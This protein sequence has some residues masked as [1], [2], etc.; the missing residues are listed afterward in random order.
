MSATFKKAAGAMAAKVVVT[1]MVVV[2]TPEVS[3]PVPMVKPKDAVVGTKRSSRPSTVGR[4]L[5]AGFRMRDFLG[6]LLWNSLIETSLSQLW[7][8]RVIMMPPSW[9]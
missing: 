7:E 9:N 5:H 8:M 1:P 6:G 2:V 4:E 3:A